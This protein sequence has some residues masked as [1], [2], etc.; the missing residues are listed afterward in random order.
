MEL[1]RTLA[2]LAEPPSPETERLATL[3]GLPA[4]PTA[5]AHTDLLGFQLYPYASVYLGS[6][7]MLGGEARDRI[8]G[9]WRVLGETPPVEPDHLVVLLGLYARLAELALEQAN[10]RARAALL[11]AKRALLWEHVLSWIPFYL[12]KIVEIGPEPYGSWARLLAATLRAEAASGPQPEEL[13]LHLREAPALDGLEDRETLTRS[14]L[15]PVRTGIVLTRTDLV[16]ASR[17]L[18]LALRA[19]ERRFVLGA[20]LDQDPRGTIRWLADEAERW[21]ARHAARDDDSGIAGF[22]SERAGRT[23]DLLRALV[24]AQEVVHVGDAVDQTH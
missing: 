3:L 24:R 11:Q 1:I 7:G 10:P 5:E 4:A 9:F 13:P 12:D 19:G 14:L 22:W 6:E 15:V 17:D 21:V 18:G 20:F 8:A 23:A 16:R 2:V